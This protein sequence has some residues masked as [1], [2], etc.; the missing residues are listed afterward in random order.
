MNSGRLPGDWCRPGARPSSEALGAGGKLVADQRRARTSSRLMAVVWRGPREIDLDADGGGGC[1]PWM[2]DRGPTPLEL[3]QALP[4]GWCRLRSLSCRSDTVGRGPLP[5][6]TIGGGP[7]RVSPWN[8]SADRG[9]VRGQRGRWPQLIAGLG[10]SLRGG[11]RCPRF[12]LETAG[13][14]LADSERARRGHQLAARGFCPKFAPRRRRPSPAPPW[15]RGLAPGKTAWVTLDGREIDL[16][17]RGDW[18]AADSPE[19]P[20]R[21]DRDAEAARGG[22]GADG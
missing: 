7:G 16:W 11:H 19:L 3:A 17:Q 12:E 1:P 13:V 18:A 14:D 21:H 4:P 6:S 22:D 20:P 8:R 10:R 5:A 15:C 9:S 2:V